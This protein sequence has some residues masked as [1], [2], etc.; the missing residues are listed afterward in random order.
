MKFT[1]RQITGGM[2]AVPLLSL[3]G[4]CS[5][6]NDNDVTIWAMGNEAASLPKLLRDVSVIS[7]QQKIVVQT[8][9]WSAAHEK[10][11][12]GYAGGSLPTIGQIGNSWLAEMVA[13]G[14]ILPVPGSTQAILADQ[15]HAVLETNRIAGQ[16][17]AAPWY[18][19]TRLQFYR[20]DIFNKAGYAAPPLEWGAWKA[21][22][23]K[24]K[25]SAPSGSYAA[26]LPLNE[27]EQL[28]TIAL[29]SGA[30]M[31]RDRNSRGAFAEPEFIDALTFYK[32]LFDEKLAP[33]VTATQVSNI[34]NEFAKGQFSVFISGPWT[35]GDLRKRL[36]VSL[37]NAWG[38]APN[39]GP[40]GIGSAAPGGSSLVVF[41]NGEDTAAAWNI[42]EGLLAPTA[43]T[44]FHKLTGNLPAR[45]SVWTTAGLAHDPIIAPFS[46]QL[47]RATALPKVPE[48]ERIVTEMQVVAEQMVRGTLS[49]K[50]AAQEINAR[51]DRLL[52]KRRW[53]LNRG[54]A[55]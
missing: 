38:T 40:N 7:T 47:E 48:W 10:L 23:H 55:L 35:V 3:A 17:W 12:T 5:T 8:L 25:Q 49:V 26:L 33:T 28:L 31:L 43:Q 18:V 13:I 32:S 39:P 6:S 20:S 14:A 4:G 30:R 44:E 22:L 45:R 46:T 2:I 9:P 29:S 50:A 52:E 36:P 37:Q 27:F 41:S 19:D 53:M 11:L 34:W 51:A 21:A 15:F 1:R 42:I 54:L 24:I 16:I